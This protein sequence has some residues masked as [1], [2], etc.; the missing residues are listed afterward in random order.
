MF[1]VHAC[2]RLSKQQGT[3]NVVFVH[4]LFKFAK[5]GLYQKPIFL[6]LPKKEKLVIILEFYIQVF[7]ISSENPLIFVIQI[8]QTTFKGENWK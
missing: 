7:H 1:K 3:E 2:V 5:I 4:F 8:E 6:C